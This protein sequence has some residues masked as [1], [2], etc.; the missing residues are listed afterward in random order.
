METPLIDTLLRAKSPARPAR[1]ERKR[2]RPALGA[3]EHLES[4]QLLSVAPPVTGPTF[5]VADTVTNDWY[6]PSNGQLWGMA[7]IAAPKAWDAQRGS[8][9][10]VVADIDT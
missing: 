9:K 5:H 4:R 1:T 3:V 8:T 10:V 6:S 7:K 2:F